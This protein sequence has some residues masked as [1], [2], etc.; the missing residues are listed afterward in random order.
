MAEA[1]ST[2]AP[3]TV[4][5]KRISV[6]RQHDS[7]QAPTRYSR[8]LT[9]IMSA[10]LTSAI[11]RV[12]FLALIFIPPTPPEVHKL[13]LEAT[14]SD[15]VFTLPVVVHVVHTG[16]P[17]GSQFNPSDSLIHAMI[18]SLNG[19]W[20][21][22]EAMSG[23]ADM[24]MQFALATRGPD[25]S[26]TTGIVRVDG[27]VYSDY[28]SGGI[29]NIGAAGSVDEVLVKGLSRWSNTDFINFWIVNKINGSETSPGGYAYFPEY[30]N[31]LIDGIVLLASVVNG[32][33]KTVVHEMGHVFYLHHPYNGSVGMTCAPDT[34]CL[35]DGD[36]VCDTE[37][38]VY[39]WD[40]STETNVC[41]SSPFEIADDDFGYTILNNYMGYTDCQYM[42]TEGQKTRARDALC[43]FRPGLLTSGAFSPPGDV[44]TSACIPT[45]SN[46]LSP[47]YGIQLVE[48]GPMVVYSNTSA[49]DGAFYIDRTCNQQVTLTA[50]ETYLLRITGSYYN[51]QQ[52]KAWIDFDANGT[53]SESELLIDASGGFVED[54]I[55]MPLTGIAF[56]TPL[57]LRIVS[58]L[59]GAPTPDPCHLTGDT[60]GGVGQIEDYSV[61]VLRREVFSTAS[62]P[63]DSEDTWS[64]ACVPSADDN[65]TIKATDT[66]TIE[67]L[68]DTARCARLYLESGSALISQGEIVV[69]E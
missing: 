56:D 36:L 16:G 65:I 44:P 28:M 31:A 27:T 57:R 66:V 2:D 22:M 55:E 59:P 62:G 61:R 46:G 42:F 26:A 69:R 32:D 40:C 8:Y 6:D 11:I 52:S 34:N 50:G 67:A 58:E 49:A 51:W 9:S 4:P 10:F 7:T 64:C 29:T 63:W 21:K 1:G 38:S 25:C 3:A 5:P 18:A 17:V 20:R 37:A 35:V 14:E 23:G 30:N 60:L 45:A 68:S 13:S 39:L 43:A 54:S 53:F 41:T 47:Y 12:F 15:S 24:E 33:N 48:L 19:S